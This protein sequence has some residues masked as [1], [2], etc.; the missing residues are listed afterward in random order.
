MT[1]WSL[2]VKVGIYAALLT[3]AALVAGAGVMMLTLYFYQISELDEELHGDAKE[4]VWDLQNFRDA[5]K[6][7]RAPLS[8]KF[9]P[10]DMREDYLVI[11]GPEG[12]I[13]YQSANLKGALLGGALGEARTINFAPIRTT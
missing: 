3:M 8:A 12:Q 5:P 11:E 10:V 13:L 6:D 9:I 4:L 7:P 2:K 1:R